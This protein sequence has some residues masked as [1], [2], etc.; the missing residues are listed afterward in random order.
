[1]NY[2]SNILHEVPVCADLLKAE[3]LLKSKSVVK[4]TEIKMLLF[5]IRHII[6]DLVRLS[7]VNIEME[8]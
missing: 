1:M 2:I 5:F 7:A 4:I 3:L 8:L 6:I